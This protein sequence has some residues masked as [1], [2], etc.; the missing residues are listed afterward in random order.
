MARR[1]AYP[2]GCLVAD[3]FKAFLFDKC[4]IVIAA[5]FSVGFDQTKHRVVPGNRWRRRDGHGL[6]DVVRRHRGSGKTANA[7]N[8][9]NCS[10]GK[11][12]PPRRGGV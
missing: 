10:H 7:N 5:S 11:E 9:A 1:L 3:P 12:T 4:G 8:A 6:G 2:I